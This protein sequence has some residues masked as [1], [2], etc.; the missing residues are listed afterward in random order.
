MNMKLVMT[1]ANQG[2]RLGILVAALSIPTLAIA[3]PLTIE[4][5]DTASLLPQGAAAIVS[6]EVS[7]GEPAN[8]EIFNDTLSVLLTQHLEN[9]TV[10]GF[11]YTDDFDCSS[12]PQIVE[13]TV[14]TPRAFREGQADAEASLS[15]CGPEGCKTIRDIEEV[16]L[17]GD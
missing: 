4:I 7:C 15:A 9:G 5:E 14:S 11:G 10:Q 13:V 8:I 6:V 2:C 12:T 3:Q 1:T 16:T 17:V